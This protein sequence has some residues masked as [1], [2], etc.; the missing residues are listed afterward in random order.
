MSTHPPPTNQQARIWA[1]L[2]SPARWPG[3]VVLLVVAAVHVPVTP[4]HLH[5]ATYIGV[6]FIALSTA[7]VALAVLVIIADSTPVW[8]ATVV[9][10]ALALIAYVVSRSTALPQI[11]GDVGNWTEPLGMAAVL[12]EV[13]S[14]L[15]AA[16]VLI[17]HVPRKWTLW[18]LV[19]ATVLFTAGCSTAIG[20]ASHQH[21]MPDGTT[22]TDSAMP[23]S[24][25]SDAAKETI[26]SPSESARM[27]CSEEIR[28]AVVRGFG[29]SH[30]PASTSTWAHQVYSCTYRLPQGDL[31]L[32]VYDATDGTSGTT[33][34]AQARSELEGAK[35]IGG[36]QSFGLPAFQT[37][38]G[39]VLFLTDGKTLRVDASALPGS[40]FPAGFTA[41]QTAYSVAAAVIACWTE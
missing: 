11:G 40:A 23:H 37:S 31:R 14:V 17:E 13:V 26:G 12:A 16:S 41:Q 7:C 35:T 36:M 32:S 27:I 2:R 6:L 33:H 10:N 18:G 29:L 4:E 24:S 25:T 39:N 34:F 8:L 22:M 38:T 19:A 5:E 20:E 9:A 21:T 1:A 28:D 30:L 3:A 15:I